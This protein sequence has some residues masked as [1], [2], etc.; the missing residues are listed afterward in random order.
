MYLG[1]ICFI[2][3]RRHTK[4]SYEE[5]VR[6][7]LEAGIRWIQYRHK[8]GQR[9]DL[10]R[11]A[12]SLR[13]LT[14][15]FG[16]TFIVN[17][18]VDIA[19]AVDADGV[20]LG[21]EDLPIEK[22]REALGKDKLIGLSTHTVEQAVRAETAG[23]DYIGVGPVFHTATKDAGRPRG[24]GILRAVRRRVSIPIVAIGGI[25][26][27]NVGAVF[28]TGIDAVAVASALVKGDIR[29]NARRFLERIRLIASYQS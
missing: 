1:G 20:H 25:T 8:E 3:D 2:T 27:E 21:Q 9:R 22:A 26:H 13:E 7:A 12:L 15:I 10:L 4:A 24:I 17:D 29:E 5:M 6:L 16:A 18:Y 23:A 19:L 11:N 14:K 28:E